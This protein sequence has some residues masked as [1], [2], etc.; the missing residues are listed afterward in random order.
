MNIA[1]IH[2]TRHSLL[3]NITTLNTTDDIE[4]LI[5]KLETKLKKYAYSK[6]IIINCPIDLFDYSI[7]NINLEDKLLEAVNNDFITFEY[8][9]SN[10]EKIITQYVKYDD[11]DRIMSLINEQGTLDFP[12]HYAFCIEPTSQWPNIELNLHTYSWENTLKLNS[13]FIA[14]HH[15]GVTQ[16][17]SWSKKNYEFLDFHDDIEDTLHS[18]KIG[19]YTNYKQLV[20][21]ALNCLNQS[22]HFI[23]NDPQKNQDD[24]NVISEYTQRIGRSLSCSRQGSTKLHWDF[25]NTNSNE[26]E[27]IN[28][29]Y[30]LKI[31]WDDCGNKIPRGNGNPVRIYF[32]L[33]SYPGFERKQIKIAHIGKHL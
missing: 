16:F 23:S 15:T 4:C 21:H 25:F 5:D 28:C 12:R 10:L 24:L 18:I 19:D 3:N 7:D 22:Y 32:G 6:N 14:Q 13:D 2:I 1:K 27:T 26:N 20:S 8:Y 33:K 9:F 30:H 31:N 29:E 17:I 11:T